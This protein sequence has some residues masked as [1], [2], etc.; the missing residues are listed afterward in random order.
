MRHIRNEKL[1]LSIS[2]VLKELREAR[3]VTQQDV[4]M[5]TSIHIGRIEACRSNPSVSTISALLKYFR[6][7]MSDFYIMVEK[8]MAHTTYEKENK[9][10]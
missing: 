1:L 5:D 7:K 10:C 4:Y 8:R 6:I 3:G 2:L 9:Y